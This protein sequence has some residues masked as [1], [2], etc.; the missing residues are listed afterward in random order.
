MRGGRR[1]LQR[2][3]P[4]TARRLRP[5]HAGNEDGVGRDTPAGRLSMGRPPAI[6][7]VRRCLPHCGMRQYSRSI[8]A[9]NSGPRDIACRVENRRNEQNLNESDHHQRPSRAGHDA[10]CGRLSQPRAVAHP[11][12][13][14]DHTTGD[15]RAH[16]V[17]DDDRVPYERHAEALASEGLL[18]PCA[19]LA[20]IDAPCPPRWC[21]FSACREVHVLQSNVASPALQ[22]EHPRVTYR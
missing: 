20:T 4:E 21:V 15:R 13:A 16:Q 5:M 10:K 7:P 22:C 19:R 8:G 18:R 3:R 12:A 2:G 9:T 11:A 6:G 17:G 1:R 14:D